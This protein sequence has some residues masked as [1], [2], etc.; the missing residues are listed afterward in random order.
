MHNARTKRILKEKLGDFRAIS[1]ILAS[2]HQLALHCEV[3]YIARFV[4]RAMH[5]V[6]R[7]TLVGV[8]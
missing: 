4:A 5:A 3:C 7:D 6:G 2:V 8:R 1:N